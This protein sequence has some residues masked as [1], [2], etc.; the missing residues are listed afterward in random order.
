MSIDEATTQDRSAD[1]SRDLPES[2][3][4]VACL[5]L[6]EKRVPEAEIGEYAPEDPVELAREIRQRDRITECVVLVTCNRVEVYTST[7]T[8]EDVETALR[9]AQRALGEPAGARTYAGLSVAEHLAQVA[10]GLESPIL[11]EDEILG[12][13]NRAF[14]TATAEGLAEGALRR[15]AET[16]VRVG[17]ACRDETGID[18]GEMG[19]ASAVCRFV[20][21]GL[22]RSP[23]RVLVVGAGEM[24]DT[25]AEAITRR[26]QTTVD[27]ANRSPAFDLT[28][29]DGA[30][31]PLV[32]ADVAAS[33]VDAVVS[34]TGASDPVLSEDVV[35]NCSGPV[36]DLAN[37]PDL[38]AEAR[39]RACVTTLETVTSYVEGNAESRRKAV[40]AVEERIDEAI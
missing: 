35:E 20:E 4:R 27:V 36:I 37:P 32:E 24:A 33:N 23:D 18:D 13:V 12:Q 26:W 19:Y 40:G 22:D 3:R 39:E 10:C 1:P 8:A 7:R 30:Y 5:S 28:T 17:R 9:A 6:S 34:A 31:W 29:A 11:G 38:P 15:I 16:A 25:V 21:E 2:L 14:E